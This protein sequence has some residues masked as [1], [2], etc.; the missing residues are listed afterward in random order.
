MS[1]QVYLIRHG[2]A[3]DRALSDQDETR[4]LTEQGQKK[5]KKV[6]KA[7]KETGIKFDRILTS[8]LLRARETAEIL[9]EKGLTET[10]ETFSPLSPNGNIQDW[11][12][13]WD[14]WQQETVALVGHQP[15][16]GNWAELLVW[17]KA[18]EKLVVKKAGVIGLHC[19]EN[20][21][22]F[23]KSELFLLTSPKWLIN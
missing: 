13:W 4:P 1:K 7:L 19:P 8:P 2:I 9:K 5:T 15:D 23:G 11:L 20:E 6:A 12:N 14:N 21:S 18:E 10:L 17:G 16:L 22:P 3:L